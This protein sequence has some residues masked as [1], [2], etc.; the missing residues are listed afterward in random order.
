ML[1]L[2]KDPIRDFLLHKA[3][4]QNIKEQEV[5][6]SIFNKDEDCNPLFCWI[7]AD[8]QKGLVTFKEL[9]NIK[10]FDP[11]QR[12]MW[13]VPKLKTAFKNQAEIY[14]CSPNDIVFTIFTE[15]EKAKLLK[16][17]IIKKGLT[18]KIITFEDL[19]E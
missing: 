12:E 4:K 18:K 8:G 9:L 16:I 7:T 2:F 6:I 19:L 14:E 13:G 10:I 1:K 11:F 17:K 3:A 5:A 15:E